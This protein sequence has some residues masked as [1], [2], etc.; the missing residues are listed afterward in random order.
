[1][2]VRSFE[3]AEATLLARLNVRVFNMEEIR[4]RGMDAAIT[5]ALQ[6]VQQGTAG[7][8]I[9]ID[10]DALDP[11]EEPGVGSPVADGLFG[12]EL[13]ASLTPLQQH[14]NLLG[15]ELM[16]YNPHRDHDQVTAK[17]ASDITARLLAK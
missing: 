14:L 5:D 10:L 15:L 13:L 1:M 7:F 6:I 9:S 11:R 17:M 2:G 12:S 3:S 4:Q 8:G 16:A